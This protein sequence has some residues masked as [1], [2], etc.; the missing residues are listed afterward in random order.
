MSVALIYFVGLLVGTAVT[1]PLVCSMRFIGYSAEVL[2]QP[3]VTPDDLFAKYCED[4]ER[5]AAEV[6]ARRE[7]DSASTEAPHA[8]G[9][10]AAEPIGPV[11]GIVSHST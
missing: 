8:A 3:E 4:L 2:R 7:K 1:M 11:I 5:I 9:R 6:I 10:P